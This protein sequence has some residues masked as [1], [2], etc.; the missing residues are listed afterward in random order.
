ML[1]RGINIGIPLN[2]INGPPKST[3]AFFSPFFIGAT[4]FTDEHE[5]RNI[6]KMPAI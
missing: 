6:N 1:E 4:V 2:L 3:V 5:L